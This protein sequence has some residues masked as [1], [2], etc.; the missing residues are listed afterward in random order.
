MDNYISINN[1]RIDLTYEQVEKIKDSLKV[2]VCDMK[3]ADVSA[4]ETAKIGDHEMIVLEHTGDT[5]LLLLKGLLKDDQEFGENNNYNGS[6]VDAICQEFAKEIATIVGESNIVLHDVD[7]TS[8]D[9][10]KDYGQIQRYASLL[11]TDQARR[12]VQI[13]D[14]HK[15]DAWWWLATAWSTPVHND[16]TW[17]KCVSPSGNFNGDY[18][19]SGVY[20]VRP[21]CI[22]KS[23]IFVSK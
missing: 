8:D 7:L 13:L 15:L 17:V 10:L 4:G 3:L 14:K 6:Y 11:T 9:G 1:Q 19:G 16:S 2:S 21:F 5:T 22:L 18:F 12:Y 23:D 20:G